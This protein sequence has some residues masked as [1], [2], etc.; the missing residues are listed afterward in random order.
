ME[1]V[2]KNDFLDQLEITRKIV[3][4]YDSIYLASPFFY[5]LELKAEIPSFCPSLFFDTSKIRYDKGIY[6]FGNWYIGRSKHIHYR[7]YQHI[8]SV[9]YFF[10]NGERMVNQEK[11]MKI[12]SHIVRCKPIK[13]TQL[14]TRNCPEVEKELIKQYS[15]TLTNIMH[16]PRKRK[17]RR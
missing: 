4:C 17:K 9:Y 11:S 16:N 12:F 14:S 7:L 13:V 3:T 10:L 6:M 1:R 5:H 15:K 2:L 8:L